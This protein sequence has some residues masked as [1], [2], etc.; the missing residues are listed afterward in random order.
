[1]W[2]QWCRMWPRIVCRNSHAGRN[3]RLVQSYIWLTTK[4]IVWV[5][6]SKGQSSELPIIFRP[7]V[8]LHFFRHLDNRKVQAQPDQNN[9]T[10]ES[11]DGIVK[12]DSEIFVFKF[13]NLVSAIIWLPR[14]QLPNIFLQLPH[15]FLGLDFCRFG[16]VWCEFWGKFEP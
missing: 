16:K 6:A 10:T 11:V 4:I 5:R 12:N 3:F 2:F 7:R 9:K 8:Y 15:G 14:F 1:M 13:E